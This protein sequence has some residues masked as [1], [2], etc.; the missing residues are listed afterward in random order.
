MK[1]ERQR[2]PPQYYIKL[3]DCSMY[4]VTWMNANCKVAMLFGSM[5]ERE[6]WLK[7][8]ESLEIVNNGHKLKKEDYYIY[9]SKAGLIIDYRTNKPV[10]DMYTNAYNTCK[11]EDNISYLEHRKTIVGNA[12]DKIKSRMQRIRELKIQIQD[13]DYEIAV[14]L[15]KEFEELVAATRKTIEFVRTNYLTKGGNYDQ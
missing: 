5:K 2:R 11:I 10:F 6:E 7:S 8:K 3:E 13:I 15:I 14:D 9:R 4:S 1:T 12:R